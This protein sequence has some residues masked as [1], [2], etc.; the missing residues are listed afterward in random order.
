MLALKSAERAEIRMM[1][2][3]DGDGEVKSLKEIAAL[4]KDLSSIIKNLDGE[5]GQDG[6]DALSVS[7]EGGCEKYGV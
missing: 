3:T 2:D 6:I 7:F 1:T 4:V 5:G